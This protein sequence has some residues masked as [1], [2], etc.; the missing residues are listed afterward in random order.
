MQSNRS[1]L[2]EHNRILGESIT[3]TR[4]AAVPRVELAHCRFN[5]TDMRRK[6]METILR[7]CCLWSKNINPVR[8]NNLSSFPQVIP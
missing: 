4:A 2:W 1:A 5:T 8:I 6:E 7:Y 3:A